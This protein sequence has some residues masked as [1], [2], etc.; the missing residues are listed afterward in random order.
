MKL[1]IQCAISLSFTQHLA[2][3]H[4]ETN[5]NQIVLP[6]EQSG[7]IDWS[8]VSHTVLLPQPAAMEHENPSIYP[9]EPLD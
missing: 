8:N 2:C 3:H 7:S 1:I 6:Q 4:K 9:A 5:V